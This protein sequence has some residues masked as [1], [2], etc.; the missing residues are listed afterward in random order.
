MQKSDGISPEREPEI[1]SEERRR[2][3]VSKHDQTMGG[4]HEQ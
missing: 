3:N 2:K 4:Y 1:N